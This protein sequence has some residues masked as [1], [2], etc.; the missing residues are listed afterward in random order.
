M[1]IVC[2]VLFYSVQQQCRE[3]FIAKSKA[4]TS[5]PH[6]RTHTQ[7]HIHIHTHTHTHTQSAPCCSITTSSPTQDLHLA[8]RRRGLC[9]LGHTELGLSKGPCAWPNWLCV[10]VCMCVYV[11]AGVQDCV[12]A[13]I[14][15][16]RESQV[17]FFFSGWSN[18]S[19]KECKVYVSLH[20]SRHICG[21]EVYK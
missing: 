19:F 8:V 9:C 15:L 3:T 2:T 13:S 5:C 12:L 14:C 10:C 4:Q 1:T 18:N 16:C 21:K 11:L 7:T 6:A 20:M 17:L